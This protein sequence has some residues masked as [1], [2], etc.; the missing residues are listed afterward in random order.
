MPRK[1]SL[2][3]RLLCCCQ[4]LSVILLYNMPDIVKKSTRQ[5]KKRR[6]WCGTVS[7]KSIADDSNTSCINVQDDSSTS[8]GKVQNYRLNHGLL[9]VG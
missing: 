5:P 7:K 8:S 6:T 9:K 4:L 3:L 2:S 1:Q